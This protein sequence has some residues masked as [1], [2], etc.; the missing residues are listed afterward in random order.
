[1][2]FGEI[3]ILVSAFFGIF[4]AVVFFLSMLQESFSKKNPKLKRHAKVSIIVPVWNEEARATATI[5]SLLKI[6]W[7]RDKLEIIIVNDGSTDR[8]AEF[9]EPYA[10]YS[11]IKIFTKK[12]SS[13]KAKAV[14]FGI[15][16]SSGE[17]IMSMDADST[18]DSWCLK[19]MLGYFD[20]DE[21]VMAVIPYMLIKNP[22]KFIHKLQY[23]EFLSATFMRRIFA[24][25]GGLFLAPGPGTIIRKKFF[26]KH[27]YIDETTIVEDMEISLRIQKNHYI[28][29]HAYGVSSYTLGAHTLKHFF[30][31]RLRWFRGFID[32]MGRYGELFS[33]KYGN[34]GMFILPV[35]I[36]AVI[37]NLSLFIYGMS[38]LI[39][40]TVKTFIELYL[41]NFDISTW[42][43]FSFDP[44]FISTTHLSV[45]ILVMLGIGITIMWV[46]KKEAHVKEKISG[47]YVFFIMCYWLLY[48]FS[49]IKAVY[50]KTA[51]KKI[52]WGGKVG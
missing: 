31:Q 43:D 29:E 37:L 32:M 50:Y 2:T 52:R 41:I 20:R 10:K 25:L 23:I 18:I 17:F 13:G 40:N 19:K 26:E 39:I 11:F 49:W 27:G 34:L 12:K 46:A 33:L 22:K 47:S 14:N 30:A 9:L 51:R 28:I 44:Y 36:I 15:R 45:L 7:P 4:S 24:I 21:K 1:M 5:D 6:D 16:H 48:S 38:R 42:F 35:S 8:T 3:L